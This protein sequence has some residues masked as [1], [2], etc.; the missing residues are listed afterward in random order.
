MVMNGRAFEDC[1]VREGS[2]SGSRDEDV[3]IRDRT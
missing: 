3:T 2:K 1:R